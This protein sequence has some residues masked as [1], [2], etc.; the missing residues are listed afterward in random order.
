MTP[1]EI[2]L[3]IEREFEIHGVVIDFTVFRDP[4]GVAIS[5]VEITGQGTKDQDFR[6]TLRADEASELIGKITK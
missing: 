4:Q 1:E 3:W 2:L 5:F 6:R